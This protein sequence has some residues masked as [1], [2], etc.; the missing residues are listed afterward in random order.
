MGSLTFPP[1]SCFFFQ[2]NFIFILK[3]QKEAPSMISN[4]QVF[5]SKVCELLALLSF[6]VGCSSLA[7]GGGHN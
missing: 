6:A 3:E 7:D 1:P 2:S 4:L 5:K